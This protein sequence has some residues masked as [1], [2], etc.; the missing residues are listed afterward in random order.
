M[1]A[2][3]PTWAEQMDMIK[4]VADDLMATWRPGGPT[5]AERQDMNKL[6]LSTLASGYLCRVYTDKRRPAFMPLWNFAFNQGGPNPDYV[7]LTTEIDPYGVYEIS[8]FRGTS[9]FVEITQQEPDM[10]S[11]DLIKPVSASPLRL[12]NDLDELA[13]GPEGEFSVILSATRPD[14]YAG[15]GGC[16]IR[17]PAD[18]S[19]ASVPATGS[20][21]SMLEWPSTAWT[22]PARIC[23]LLR[24]L[25]AS[26]TWSPG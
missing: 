6:L 7:Y 19:S 21:R 13:L 15:I 25:G 5:E 11:V 1:T 4:S 12:T 16:S 9:R 17:G 3:L 23:P 8:G 14:G 22:I 20:A 10:M 2:E 26:R 24:S 18:C